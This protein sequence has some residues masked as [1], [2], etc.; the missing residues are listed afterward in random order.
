MVVVPVAEE[1]GTGKGAQC[2]KKTELQTRS[3]RSRASRGRE[4]GVHRAD[5]EWLEGEATF[6]PPEDAQGG[7]CCKAAPGS[8][9]WGPLVTLMSTVSTSAGPEPDCSSL[10]CGGL[11][12]APGK[13]GGAASGCRI[14]AKQ[15]L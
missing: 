9:P 4:E 11:T 6:F 8:I 14:V 1:K 5:V 10:V 13:E 2:E 12:W 7:V 3:W 15:G